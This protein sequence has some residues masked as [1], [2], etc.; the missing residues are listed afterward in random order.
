MGVQLIAFR[1][2]VVTYLTHILEVLLS[3]TEEMLATLVT[4]QVR[5]TGEFFSTGRN[6]SQQIFK[7]GT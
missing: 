2:G 6:L 1:E 4:S 5:R 7:I 3:E